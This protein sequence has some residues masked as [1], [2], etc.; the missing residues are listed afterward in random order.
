MLQRNE[1]STRLPY[2][3]PSLS[4]MAW[5]NQPCR[6]AAHIRKPNSVTQAP[7]PWPFTHCAAP[8]MTK[9]RPVAVSTG[10]REGAGT[11]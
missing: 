7:Q 10:K 11:K 9:N 8:R 1:T 6:T 4:A 2:S 5:R 3:P